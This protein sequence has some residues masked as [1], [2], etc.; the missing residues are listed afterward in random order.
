LKNKAI[1][2]IKKTATIFAD[3]AQSQQFAGVLLIAC[4]LISLFLSNTSIQK[5]WLHFINLNYK[6]V[7]L[8]FIVNDILMAMFFLLVGLEIKR[9]LLVGELSNRKTAMLP[10]AGAIGGMAVPSMFF[11][12]FNY[13]KNTANGWAIPTATDIAFALGIMSLFG[14][15]IPLSL[16]VF[17]AA[18]AVVDDLGAI[19]IIA[20]F[21]SAHINWLFILGIIITLFL[22]KYIFKK[23]NKLFYLIYL[24]T[25]C[26]LIYLL[27]HAHLHTTLAGVLLAII[28]PFNELPNKSFLH[29][30]EHALIKPVNIFI[31]P[32]FAIFNTAIVLNASLLNNFDYN[33]LLGICLALVIGKPIGILLFSYFACKFNLAQLPENININKLL[34]VSFLGGIGF[35]MSIFISNIAYTD[36]LL[37]EQAKVA[38]LAASFLAIVLSIIIL[39]LKF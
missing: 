18:L 33:L 7:S 11:L 3:F 38:V 32:L 25:F 24:F 31:V 27:H 19:V 34:Y 23:I 5:N 13:N 1:N 36:L 10:I 14:N 4:T 6:D 28:T 15:K 2:S 17:I 21:Y 29:K 16:K 37:V 9:E 20:F 8:K 22:A 12:L 35:I 39:K 30:T 26:M